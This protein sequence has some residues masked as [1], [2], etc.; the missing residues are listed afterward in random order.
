M[1]NKTD[2]DYFNSSFKQKYI[3]KLNLYNRLK[4]ITDKFND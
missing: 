2:K 4:A 1:K 3:N